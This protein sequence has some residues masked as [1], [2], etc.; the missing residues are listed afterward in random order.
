MII[1]GDPFGANL[2]LT[3]TCLGVDPASVIGRK[4]A[5][6][7][8]QSFLGNPLE[9]PH[10]LPN[11]LG[12]MMRFEN[13]A[14]WQ[15][16][17]T[18][19]FFIGNPILAKWLDKSITADNI[20]LILGVPI[21]DT[22][23]TAESGFA[24]RFKG[25]LIVARPGNRS[26]V[27]YG[28]IW[29][30][31]QDLGDVRTPGR[32]PSLGWPTYDEMGWEGGR[33]S[34]FDQGEIHYSATAGAH[35]MRGAI[36]ARWR[37]A[38][39]VKTLGRPT[40]NELVAPDGVGRYSRFEHG[41]I[42]WT[43]AFGAFE[44]PGA[45]A[46]TWESAG[47]M[48]GWLGYPTAVTP[49]AKPPGS[50][51][52]GTLVRFQYG[53]GYL[54]DD[55]EVIVT[56]DEKTF[57]AQVLTPTGT[58]LGGNVALT[59][60]SNATWDFTC[61]MHDSGAD[62]YSFT[63]RLM[64]T[65]ANGVA[66]ALQANGSIQGHIIGGGGRDFHHEESNTISDPAQVADLQVKQQISF[67]HD[68]WP[69]IADAKFSVMHAYKDTGVLGTVEAAVDDIAAWLVGAAVGGPALASIVLIGSALGKHLGVRVVGPGGLVGVVVAGASVLFL[70]PLGFTVGMLAGVV[71]A[72]AIK[73]RTIND[74]EYRFANR[75]FK[76]TLPP[77]NQIILTNVASTDA[78]IDGGRKFT[79]PNIDGTILVNL[80][81]ACFANPMGWAGRKNYTRPGQVFIHELTHAW[82]IYHR[83]SVG[84]LC[85]YVTKR[86]ASV[87]ADAYS[88]GTPDTPFGKFGLEQQAHIVDDWY[89]GSRAAQFGH[90]ANTNDP[91][92][93]QDPFFHYIANNIWLG[94]PGVR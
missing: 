91:E 87:G 73:H 39:L 13:G 47:M 76:G 12:T 90:T 30:C 62:D 70:G 32:M 74:D 3:G 94:D 86:R 28:A 9:L 55:G 72:I 80:G 66:L 51:K 26:Y 67:L 7:G 34:P 14:I 93:Y 64:L 1:G 20:Q 54:L 8:G 18:E 41:I 2:S 22:F 56:P 46:S 77:Q 4:Y 69:D 83:A 89:G 63:V 45:L 23:A 21:E 6:L 42:A 40:S 52:V 38:D 15:V 50:A 48:D 58:A 53:F 57:S 5:A 43:A 59:V 19:A 71:S 85:D 29:S 17:L 33:L 60:R 78:D 27:V 82:Q 68:H 24:Q 10:D 35:E 81:D 92:D 65:T 36:L 31:Y 16:S 49:G 11:G 25:G 88:Y 75:I 44:V 61:H 84:L 79:V 37:S